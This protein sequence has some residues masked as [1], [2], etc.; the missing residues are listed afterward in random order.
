MMWK[1]KVEV[2]GTAVEYWYDIEDDGDCIKK[3][4]WVS[5]NGGPTQ[6]IDWT[7]YGVP[8]K[9][10]LELWVKL[11]MPKRDGRQVWYNFDKE[12]L[13]EYAK[14]IGFYDL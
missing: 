12:S 14:E 9:E 6:H 7:P 1:T 4:H 13:R 3:F 5:I 2:E 8:L 11:G 10:D